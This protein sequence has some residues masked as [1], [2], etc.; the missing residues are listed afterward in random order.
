[1]PKLLW[2][3]AP[4]LIALAAWAI[5]T[6]RGRPPSRHALNVWAERPS[7]RL[8]LGHGSARHLLGRQPAAAGVRL[9][10]PVR[11]RNVDADRAPPGA[12]FP[13]R[14]ALPHARAHPAQRR[15][16]APVR[17][18]T[19]GAV[20]SRGARL[21]RRRGGVRLGRC[22]G[23]ARRRRCRGRRRVTVFGDGGCV[24]RGGRALPC[25]LIAL[26]RRPAAARAHVD[27]GDPPPLFKRYPGA[28]RV[29]L[30]TSTSP[31]RAASTPRPSAMCSGTRAAPRSG[32]TGSSCA[33]RPRRARSSRPSSSPA[34]RSKAWPTAGGTT[35]PRRT[36]SSRSPALPRGRYARR[37]P[38]PEHGPAVS[39]SPR[40]CSVAPATSTAIAPTATSLPISA[41]RWRTCA[42][43]ARRS[44]SPRSR[45]VRPGQDGRRDRR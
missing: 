36:L 10:L 45:R 41:M 40:R 37:G 44:A 13:D 4:L 43:P 11:L 39:S 9:A 29:A 21:S 24:A 15:A 23:V 16:S 42:S 38:R 2:V 25:R 1:M 12:E 18:S 17:G 19:G 22:A 5:Q 31:T 33:R 28:R 32:A 3:A 8:C 35:T 30:P 34:A 14:L 6:L 27:W 20:R 7:A 26:S